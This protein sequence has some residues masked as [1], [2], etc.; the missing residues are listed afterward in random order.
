VGDCIFAGT[1]NYWSDRLPE[2]C[3]RGGFLLHPKVEGL[4]IPVATY[5]P[6]NLQSLEEQIDAW[7][8]SDGW[9]KAD[10]KRCANIVRDSHTW[11]DRMQ[12]ILSRS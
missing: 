3:G 2:T 7:L 9:R 12:E 5:E 6:Q 8:H 1:P 4:D 11:T 10:T